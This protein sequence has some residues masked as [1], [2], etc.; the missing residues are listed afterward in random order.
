MNKKIVGAL[1]ALVVVATGCGKSDVPAA[2]AAASGAG[3][4]P[5]SVS[6]VRAE[7][8]DFEVMLDATGT[9]SAL[10]SVDVKPQ[11]SSTVTA[12]HIRE[13]QFVRKGE[14]LFTL[15]SRSEQT[16]VAKA[17]AQLQKD[18]ASLAD[19]ERQLARSKELHAQNFVSQVAVDT[20]QTLVD[21]QRAAVAADRAA[22]E[23]ARVS[24]SYN[25]IL[26]SGSG[27]AGAISVFPGTLV[28]PSSPALVTITQLD[29][30]AVSFNLPQRN[31]N[32]ALQ[33][34]RSGGG[35][36]A[37]VLPE[38]RGTLTGK[39]QF[40]DN[41]VDAGS[42]T[43]KVKAVFD[44][45]DEKLWPGAFVGVKLAVQTLKGAIVVP[46]AAIVQGARGK[47]VYVVESGNKAAARPVEVV[48][49]AGT[50]AVVTGVQP[51]ERV[52]LDGRQ[53]VRPGSPVSERSPDAGGPTRRAASASGAGSAPGAGA[54]P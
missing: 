13:G 36:V 1:V 37:A 25:R 17:Q 32:D 52:I 21:A 53:N 10:N 16:D 22:V 4:P 50:D 35:S 54:T 5:V 48:Q 34:L 41:A 26:A 38:G 45:R 20:N 47:V 49:A 7:K 24:L 19:A 42:G 40:V 8:R 33:A 3:G 43:V 23:A 11:V 14:P 15:D 46:Q 51:G 44:N 18:L 30:I 6:T 12:V 27:R 29:P 31:L 28:Q 39:L 2:G 9:V